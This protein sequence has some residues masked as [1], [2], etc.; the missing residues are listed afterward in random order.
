MF[1][2]VMMQNHKQLVLIEAFYPMRD[3]LYGI[4]MSI[5]HVSY[6]MSLY[7]KYSILKIPIV[8]SWKPPQS[9]GLL[10]Q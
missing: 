2:K 9:V 10:K 5:I 4:V 8:L 7:T 3:F 1:M 6:N